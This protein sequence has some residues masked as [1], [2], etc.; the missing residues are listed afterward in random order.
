[1]TPQNI[2]IDTDPGDDVDDVLALAFALLRPELSV[3]AITTT[4]FDTDK[5]ARIV[6]KLLKIMGREDVPFAPGM[7]FPLRHIKPSEMEK[8]TEV[9]GYKLNHA[10][11]AQPMKRCPRPKATRSL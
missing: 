11:W 3:K 8:L 5:R 10:S 6:G 9:G 1:M 2:L 7:N 4:T